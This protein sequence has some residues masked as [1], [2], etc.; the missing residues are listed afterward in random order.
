MDELIIGEI[1]RRMRRPAYVGVCFAVFILTALCVP[2]SGTS[3]HVL[4]VDP[5]I[6]HQADNPTWISIG[7]AFVMTLV[8][9]MI[10]A[11]TINNALS[12]ARESGVLPFLQTS[13]VSRVRLLSSMFIGNLAQLLGLWLVMVISAGGMCLIRFFGVAMTPWQFIGP[14]TVLLPGLVVLAALALLTETLPI[15]RGRSGSAFISLAILVTY[16][17]ETGSGRVVGLTGVSTLIATLNHSVKA[18]TGHAV[19][20]VQVL[21]TGAVSAKG[22]RTLLFSGVS[23]NGQLWQQIAVC[24]ALAALFVGLSCVFLE[25][26]PLKAK[27]RQ[28]QAKR[29]NVVHGLIAGEALRLLATIP[30]WLKIVTMMLWVISFG[31]QWATVTSVMLPVLNLLAIALLVQAGWGINENKVADWLSLSS[32]RMYQHRSAHIVVLIAANLLL[33]LP[34]LIHFTHISWPF[35]IWCLAM[36]LLAVASGQIV[37]NG[38]LTESLVVVLWFSYLNGKTTLVPFTQVGTGAVYA[39]LT[40][41]AILVIFGWNCFKVRRVAV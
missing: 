5:T 1:T 27:H 10:G 26:R 36:P 3:L 28:H 12:T 19:R 37:G 9:P 18:V 33:N 22:H 24:L 29:D 38:R 32:R 17:S 41:I 39:G 23:F 34:V 25:R 2:T 35:I 4:A 16:F 20:G 40:L 14:L 7:V 31:V 13:R 8:L 15:L 21:G 11:M 30:M 6:F